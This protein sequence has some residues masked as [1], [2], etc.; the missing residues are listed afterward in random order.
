MAVAGAIVIAGLVTLLCQQPVANMLAGKLT[1][2]NYQGVHIPTGV[3]IAMLPAIILTFTLT[4]V[5]R[6][7]SIILWLTAACMG[8][9]IDDAIGDHE[10]RGFVGHFRALFA[11]QLTTGIVKVALVAGAGW[12]VFVPQLNIQA[13]ADLLTALL[14]VNLFNQLDLRPGRMLK[15]ALLLLAP[16]VLLTTGQGQLLAAIGTGAVLGIL[17]GDIRAR[18]MLGDA[19]AN[20]VGALAAMAL[21]LTL[22]PSGRLLALLFVFVLNLVG[23]LYSFTRLIQRLPILGWLDYLGRQRQE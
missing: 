20:L 7:H 14:T 3:G 8:G 1:Q 16:I 10:F 17:G 19:G 23:E 13:L 12:L 18:I 11:G 15:G 6:E 9:F 5:D 22:S 2:A 21:F 4:S